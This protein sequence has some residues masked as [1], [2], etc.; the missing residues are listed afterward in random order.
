MNSLPRIHELNQTY[1]T[2][3]DGGPDP[4]RQ[5]QTYQHALGYW[6]PY[7]RQFG[8]YQPTVVVPAGVWPANRNPDA[9]NSVGAITPSESE[10]AQVSGQ[11]SQRVV[12]IGVLAALAVASVIYTTRKR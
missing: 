3:R 9:R 4:I 5:N 10:Q 1:Q 2:L 11:L 12:V 6:G 7:G 8:Y